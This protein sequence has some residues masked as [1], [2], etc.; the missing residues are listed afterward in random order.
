MMHDGLYADSSGEMCFAGT[1]P[2][3]EHNFLRFIQE[4]SAV[5]CSDQRF[6]DRIVSE[7][8]AGQ[9]TMGR[10]A[11]DLHLVVDGSDL[12]VGDFRI[13]QLVQQAGG[14]LVGRCALF[15]EFCNGAGHAEQLE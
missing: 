14:L 1:G 6:V 2:A 10:K 4:R 12:T 5:Q 7:R 15:G 13:D 11:C 9:I 8:E 3:N